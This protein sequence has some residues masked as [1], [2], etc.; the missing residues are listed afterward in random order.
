MVE[1]VWLGIGLVWLYHNY[2]ICDH[3]R[4]KDVIFTFTLQ[5]TGTVWNLST[6]STCHS[7]SLSPKLSCGRL[8][9][10]NFLSLSTACNSVL[11]FMVFVIGWCAFDR[12][13]RSFVKM[14]RYQNSL[15]ES[16][17]KYKYKRSGSTHRNWRH[18]KAVLGYQ[19]SWNRRC[20][21]LFCCLGNSDRNQVSAET[22]VQ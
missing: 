9:I 17:C 14:K 3:G 20:Q 19:D 11:I 21:M 5:Q 12:A 1:I 15:K 22:N 10:K 2:E 18:R 7:L 6:D 16:Q 13:G 4:A 8:K